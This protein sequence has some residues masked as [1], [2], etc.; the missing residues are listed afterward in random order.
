HNQLGG[1]SA[2]LPPRTGKNTGREL[3][4]RCPTLSFSNSITF[5]I[6]VP[7]ERDRLS[8]PGEPGLFFEVKYRARLFSG[9]SS[10]WLQ[11]LAVMNSSLIARL[12]TPD[13]SAM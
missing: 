8:A 1:T 11:G 13:K 4:L 5:R 7:N 6:P 12:Q 9:S 10:I 2:L 3:K